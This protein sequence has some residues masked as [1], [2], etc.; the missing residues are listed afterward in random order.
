MH[1]IVKKGQKEDAYFPLAVTS[2]KRNARQR[3]QLGLC[4][5]EGQ[6][7]EGEQGKG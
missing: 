1:A 6:K 4:I 7:L 2:N 3:C 5:A